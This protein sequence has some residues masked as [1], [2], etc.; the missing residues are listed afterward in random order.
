MGPQVWRDS[1]AAG[2]RRPKEA[3]EGKMRMESTS[4]LATAH[5]PVIMDA[6]AVSWR[7]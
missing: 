3:L 4:V 7:R 2:I 6:V 5:A 1:P